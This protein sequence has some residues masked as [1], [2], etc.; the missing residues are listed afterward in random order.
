ML[1]GVYFMKQVEASISDNLHELKNLDSIKVFE[2]FQY[3]KLIIL[4]LIR[5][6][7]LEQYAQVNLI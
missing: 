2:G 1:V 3:S 4:G 5:R 6:P 7:M